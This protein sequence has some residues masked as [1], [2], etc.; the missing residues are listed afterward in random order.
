LAPLLFV[1][2]NQINLQIPWEVD[3]TMGPVTVV[4]TVDGVASDPVEVPLAPFAPGIFTFDFG[5]GRA[6]AINLDRTVAHPVGSIAGVSSHPV[7]IGEALIILATGLGP[8]TPPAETGNNSLDDQ[9]NFV[10][11][12]TTTIPKVFIDGVEAQV[13]FSGMSPE[14]VGVYQLNV[15]VPEGVQPGDAVSLVIEIGGVR[16][17]EDVTIA[18]SP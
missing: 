8:V 7:A 5:P 17:R 3:T 1:T 12:D 2:N 9:G 18:V 15:I 10:R 6:V 13:L 16:S 14:F 4:V 11:R